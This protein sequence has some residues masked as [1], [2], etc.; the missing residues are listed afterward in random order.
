MR[1]Y[2]P[3]MDSKVCINICTY[4]VYYPS[5]YS[6]TFLCSLSF[7]FFFLVFYLL[8]FLSL[9]CGYVLLG[10]CFGDLFGVWR[11]KLTLDG[12]LQD[13]KGFQVRGEK[14]RKRKKEQKKTSEWQQY[15][16]LLPLKYSLFLHAFFVV[17]L[18][19]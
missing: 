1:C 3:L 8:S 5:L 12:Y 4:I 7:S 2:A 11:W 9:I 10:K 6:S 13:F 18:G 14:E 19:T 16:T 15:G 17:P